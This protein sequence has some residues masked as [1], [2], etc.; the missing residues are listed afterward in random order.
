MLHLSN[1]GEVYSPKYVWVWLLAAFKAG[2][3]NSAGFLA[4]GNF[5]SHVTGFG[6]QVGIA[7]GH[8]DF[9]FGSELLIIPVAYIDRKSVV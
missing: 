6:T 5:V 8:H 1:I 7:L 9:F 4:T 2:F 3:I